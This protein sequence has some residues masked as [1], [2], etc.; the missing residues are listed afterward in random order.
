MFELPKLEEAEFIDTSLVDP[1]LICD[2]QDASVTGKFGPFGLLALATKDLT[3]QTAIFF[4]VFRDHKD[5]KVLMCS[6]QK[7]L[8]TTSVQNYPQFKQ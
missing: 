4:R 8:V 3:E 5:Y 7:R 6:D 1:Q 2:K